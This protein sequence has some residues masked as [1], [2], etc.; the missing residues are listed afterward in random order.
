VNTAAVGAAQ[1]YGRREA[2]DLIA[3]KEVGLP[4]YR[5][6]TAAIVMAEKALPA[7]QEFVLRAI[8][9]EMNTVE[10]ATALLGL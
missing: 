10:L 7:M 3:F 6:N 9:A 4:L 8:D 1:R 5:L 2:F